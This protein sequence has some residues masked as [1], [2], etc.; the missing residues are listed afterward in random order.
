MHYTNLAFVMVTI[1]ASPFP[2]LFF[3]NKKKKENVQNMLPLSY[4]KTFGRHVC[5]HA[6]LLCVHIHAL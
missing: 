1:E 6:F 5:K 2:I 4:S 3:A